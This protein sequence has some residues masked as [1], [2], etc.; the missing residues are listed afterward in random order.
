MGG[1]VFGMAR[2]WVGQWGVWGA[3]R[4]RDGSERGTRCDGGLEMG[5]AVHHTCS[6]GHGVVEGQAG[7]YN[8]MGRTF[9]RR[10]THVLARSRRQARRAC[11]VTPLYLQL[12][13]AAPLLSRL[14]VEQVHLI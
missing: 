14:Q 6:L 11:G 2:E 10:T 9:G 8:E 12:E 4:C 3:C 5:W 7:R 13:S 1:W